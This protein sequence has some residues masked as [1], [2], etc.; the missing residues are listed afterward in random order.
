MLKRCKQKPWHEVLCY[1]LTRVHP[2]TLRR[3]YEQ[4]RQDKGLTPRCDNPECRYHT[5]LLVWDGKLLPLILDH[6]E[7]NRWD[8]R[9]EMLRYLCPNCDSQLFTRG[10]ANKGRIAQATDTGFI[11]MSRE[12]AREYTYFGSLSIS[13][14][15][16]AQVSFIKPSNSKEK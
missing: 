10:G 11:L 1:R 4:W 8:N 3:Y 2:G 7:G 13:L 6:V 12:G 5:E 15:A 9:P 14:T 16:N